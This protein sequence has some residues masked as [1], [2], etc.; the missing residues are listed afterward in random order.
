MITNSQTY[1]LMR[2]MFCS[3]VLFLASTKAKTIEML[4]KKWIN[5]ERNKRETLKFNPGIS[6]H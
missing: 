2:F 6:V 5:E 1:I 3:A 4:G